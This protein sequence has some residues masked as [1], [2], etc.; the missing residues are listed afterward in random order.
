MHALHVVHRDI[1]S[2]NVFVSEG[3]VLKL[4]DFGLSA[5][6]KQIVTRTKY[7]HVGTDCY[8]PPEMRTG[9]L[10]GKGKAVDIWCLGLVLLE[11]CA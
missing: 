6:T 3:Q 7:S 11:I 10:H 2:P 1:K 4:G 5:L 8:K 9:R